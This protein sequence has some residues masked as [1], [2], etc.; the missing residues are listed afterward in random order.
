MRSQSRNRFAGD[1]LAAA[2]MAAE[3]QREKKSDVAMSS[4]EG[5]PVKSTS[6]DFQ[7][8]GQQGEFAGAADQYRG[9]FDDFTARLQA[10]DIN[11]GLAQPKP[12]TA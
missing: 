11:A 4:V 6:R 3:Q 9:H 5:T 7:R 8:V 10:F 2:F 1:E 12:P